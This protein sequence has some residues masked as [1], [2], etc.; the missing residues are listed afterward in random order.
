MQCA[1]LHRRG[2]AITHWRRYRPRIVLPAET[3][4]RDTNREFCAAPPLYSGFTAS[5]I[6]V[7]GSAR[8]EPLSKLVCLLYP[9]MIAGDS[10][11]AAHIPRPTDWEYRG[12]F[13]R[14]GGLR[15]DCTTRSLSRQILYFQGESR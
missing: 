10:S 13:M 3:T 6:D 12:V 11:L 2:G 14:Q 1:L 5:T 4:I 9:S 7:R 15:L 8:I